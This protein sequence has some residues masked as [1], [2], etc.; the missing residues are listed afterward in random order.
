[1]VITDST[2]ATSKLTGIPIIGLH[3]SEIFDA[4]QLKNYERR[5]NRCRNSGDPQWVEYIIEGEHLICLMIR[6][7]TGAIIYE[8]A[9]VEFKDKDEAKKMLKIAATNVRRYATKKKIGR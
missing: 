3:L 6:T 8:T 7:P 4:V 9:G 1:M 5:F 2:V